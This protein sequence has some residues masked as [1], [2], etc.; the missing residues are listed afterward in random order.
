M[1][2][3]GE[4]QMEIHTCGFCGNQLQPS[5]DICPACLKT[6]GKS[7]QTPS[8][9]DIKVAS[10]PLRIFAA[11]I[12]LFF[13]TIIGVLV[14]IIPLA[15]LGTL[16]V[17]T[18]WYAVLNLLA[19]SVTIWSIAATLY[20]TFPEAVWG[21]S[22]GKRML[23]LQVRSINGARNCIIKTLIRQAVRIGVLS[24]LPFEG[25]GLVTGL[26]VLLYYGTMALSQKSGT[27]GD[28]LSGTIVVSDG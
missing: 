5:A 7:G 4:N 22:P 17:N 10:F 8:S 9:T 16:D 12:D 25:I 24:P 6:F 28:L 18:R 1:T 15:Y 14:S 26:T 2:T 23:N 19:S 27:L 13:L 11:F 20:F 21:T 3:G